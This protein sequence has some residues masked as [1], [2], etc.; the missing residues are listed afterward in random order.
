MSSCDAFNGV[1]C[2]SMIC[3]IVADVTGNAEAIGDICLI[4]LCL[5]VAG[6]LVA[7]EATA[8]FKKI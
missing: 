7:E 4:G 8:F 3:M 1:L 5:A 2:L 6:A